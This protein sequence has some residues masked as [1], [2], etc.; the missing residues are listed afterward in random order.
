VSTPAET[1]ELPVA[2]RSVA[3]P[4][5]SG[6]TLATVA[7]GTLLAALALEGQGGLQLGP[8]TT[9][10]MVVEILA[11]V[12]GAAAMLFGARAGLIPG[13]VA[14]AVFA[15]LVGFT[16][17]SIGWAIETGD[18]WIEA[19]RT[20]AWFAAFALG[21]ALARLWPD[22]W[23]MVL[24][25]LIFAAVE[26]CGYAVLTKAFPAAFN[27]GEIYARLREP[28]G[29]W[30]SVGL[31]SAMGLPACLWLGARRSGHAAVNALA[32]PALALLLV[33]CLL[34]YSR[35]SLLAIV[36]GCAFWFAVVP[37]RLRGAAVLA[38]GGAGGLAV[39]LWA[40][41]VPALS[42][43]RVP[44]DPRVV[45]GDDFA[46]V[47]VAM[48]AC[49][50]IAGLAI[51]FALAERAPS[52]TTRWRLGL[53]TLTCVALVP[54]LLAGWLATSE[55]GLGGSISKAWTDLTDPNARVPANDP[56]RLAAI[57]SVRARYW[58]EALKIWRA[59]EAVGVGAGG[60]RTARL[61][62]RQDTLTVRQA[63]GYVVQTLADLGL[64]GLTISLALLAAW[65]ASAVFA[66]GPW[67]RSARGTPF[68]AERI[69]LLTMCAIVVVFGVHSTVDWSWFVPG[70]AVLALIVAGWVSGRV[71]PL[72]PRPAGATSRWSAR[73]ALHNPARV[74]GAVTALVVAAIAVWTTWQPQRSVNATDDA[75]VAVEA[76]RLPD[77]RADVRRARD[78]NPLSTTPLY[79][80][81][82]VESA[83]GND[84]GARRL[85]VEAT[86][87]QPSSSEPWL[88]LAQFD[89]DRNDPRGA[90]RALGPALFL[91][92]RSTTI[93]QLHVAASQAETARRGG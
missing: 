42:T 80:G 84:A 24:G 26:V 62:Y 33:A 69:G 28:F 73:A 74:A 4:G 82:T 19:N 78:A 8:L 12:A 32:Y 17:L 40:F 72:P 65:I 70:N 5:L 79:V 76:N 46:I 61:R 18:A 64:I 71:P 47:L 66:T 44:L 93:Q 1:A 68:T 27:P 9:V 36:V 34:A 6:R 43:D 13:A 67:R 41:S 56:T 58:D 49:E 25:G 89:L 92:P 77:A 39:G 75:L 60:Y 63:H 83:A 31:L 16:A 3:L 88:R 55:R 87:M 23:S 48:L 20:L 15:L 59:D 45:A 22:G 81:A 2:A 14:L 38:L 86:R 21:V 7:F 50:L 30:N 37:L 90:L 10:E 91:D 29:Y 52:P 11:G 35:G 57:G 53:A 85:L 51:G 54:V